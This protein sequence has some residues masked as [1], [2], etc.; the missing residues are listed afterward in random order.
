MTHNL[1]H[2]QKKALTLPDFMKIVQ[3]QSPLVGNV[4]LICIQVNSCLLFLCFLFE[5][6]SIE[7]KRM[8]WVTI[9]VCKLCHMMTF[10]LRSI[11]VFC[12]RAAL[13]WNITLSILLDAGCWTYSMQPNHSRRTSSSGE[14]T[15]IQAKNQTTT[16][17][18]SRAPSTD[19][20]LPLCTDRN[21]YQILEGRHVSNN[22]RKPSFWNKRVKK[23]VEIIYVECIYHEW[24]FTFISE[25]ASLY[26]V[27]YRWIQAWIQAK[28]KTHCRKTLSLEQIGADERYW[29]FISVLTSSE[30]ALTARQ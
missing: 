24:T 20:S 8:D 7:R 13:T 15:G 10:R 3:V 12:D 26:L 29:T 22:D 30:W 28:T 2:N 1:I 14:P 16:Y 9:Q 18:R 4:G 27:T 21:H 6:H 11:N 19:L 17:C 25:L 23:T 5:V